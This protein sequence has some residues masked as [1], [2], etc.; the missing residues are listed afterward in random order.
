MLKSKVIVVLKTFSA[1]E[2]KSFRNYLRSPIHNTNKKVIKLYELIKKHHPGLDSTNI[3]KEL[4]Y[5]KLYPGKKY[6]DI[7]MRILISD[8]LRLS[9][10]FL[11][12]QR[13]SKEFFA[14]K[15]FLLEELKERKLESLFYRHIKESE[16]YLDKDG[17]MN[18]SYFLNR[19]NIESAKVN[20]LIASDKQDRSGS[21]KASQGEYLVDF[22]LVNGLNILQELHEL[23]EVLN[24][25]HNFSLIE[26][27]FN[28]LNVDN[29]INELKLN[30][31]KYYPVIEIYYNL[32]RF[33]KNVKS[34]E[35]FFRL[36]NSIV[37]NLKLFDDEEK[38][39]LLLGLESCA[40]T[41]IRIG[42]DKGQE[43]LMEV[44]EL[45]L[46]Q[47]VFSGSN[48]KFMQANLFRNIF[49]T[50]VILKKYD[51]AEKFAGEFSDY[52]VPEQKQDMYNYTIALLSFERE[53]YSKAIEYI[54]KVNYS[55]FVFKYEA[56][57]LML[58]IYYELK[59][60][61]QV[62]SLID[63]FSH[64]LA[65]NKSVS[66]INKEPFNIFLKFIKQLVKLNSNLKK[67]DKFKSIELLKQ[68]ESSE[69]FISKR[70]IIEK[71]KLLK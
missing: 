41:R 45:I 21:A 61:E 54:S 26:I 38:F 17:T 28:N 12:Y 53:E 4:L 9:E 51:W 15:S 64:F 6:S 22:V 13:Y 23:K 3:Q 10:E 2:I 46:S 47:K 67:E 39:N 34:N 5:K 37:D 57:I 36:K 62:L 55:F 56:K 59:L 42:M 32:Y 50:A 19:F 60:F 29:V 25:K 58:K 30:E 11:A 52:L 31:Y 71:I 70:W 48:R 14:E 65:K 24:V 1:D 49:Y 20:Y 8:L 35:H 66:E 16:Q 43:D 44:Y 63:S 68:A 69:H 7:V 40:I 33:S 18:Y 27:F